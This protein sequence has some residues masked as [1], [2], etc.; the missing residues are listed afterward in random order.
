MKMGPLADVTFWKT[1]W[2]NQVA[3]LEGIGHPTDLAG[4]WAYRDAEYAR[5]E[6]W[7]LYRDKLLTAWAARNARRIRRAA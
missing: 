3:R 1:E 2:R 5:D 4:E 7:A 6:A